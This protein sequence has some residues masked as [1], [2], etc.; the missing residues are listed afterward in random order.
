MHDRPVDQFKRDE[1]VDITVFNYNE[2]DFEKKLRDCQRTPMQWT[3]ESPNA[4]FTSSTTKP[5]LP[6]AETF[7]QINVKTQLEAK[8][9]HLKLFQQLVR[10]REQSP[11]YGG[12]QKKVIATKELYGFV[13][14]L[15]DLV[16]VVFLN[17]NRIGEKPVKINVKNLLECQTNDLIGEIVARSTNIEENSPLANEGEKINLNQ[18]V[19]QSCDAVVLK[20]VEPVEKILFCSK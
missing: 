6:L 16:Y 9:S 5:F 19:L 17:V 8:R 15:D 10:L 4:G 7:S 2:K 12:H 20:L 14:W 3:N 13:R 1:I 11:F 18:I